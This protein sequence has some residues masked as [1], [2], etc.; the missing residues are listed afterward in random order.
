MK[1]LLLICCMLVSASAAAQ[2]YK[3]TVNGRTV[4]AD[5]RCSPQAGVVKI[6]PGPAAPTE[7]EIKAKTVLAE[8]ATKANVIL[9]RRTVDAEIAR[10]Q[11]SL[12][13]VNY[14]KEQSLA[15]LRA[16]KQLANNNL[17]GATWEQSISTE[18][19]A[20]TASYE[21]KINRLQDTLNNLRT[22]RTQLDKQSP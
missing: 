10:I 8:N 4:Y 17:A 16:K 5:S 12:D 7:S 21:G 2:V 1:K 13:A 22:E 6:M 15:H 3:C 19:Q 20:V 14:Q 9:K 18:M 11:S